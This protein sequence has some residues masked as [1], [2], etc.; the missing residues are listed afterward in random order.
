MI[1]YER[2]VFLCFYHQTNLWIVTSSPMLSWRGWGGKHIWRELWGSFWCDR[3]VVAW[4]WNTCSMVRWFLCIGRSPG[5]FSYN[6]PI[7]SGGG[8]WGGLGW[9]ER[10]KW[11]RGQPLWDGMAAVI[12]S[13]GTDVQLHLLPLPEQVHQAG[14]DGD[15]D[16]DD[17]DDEQEGDHAGDHQVEHLPRVSQSVRHVR[18][19][20]YSCQSGTICSEFWICLLI[21]LRHV[22]LLKGVP[23]LPH[24]HIHSIE[25][26]PVLLL[27]WLL[28]LLGKGTISIAG[29]RLPA[30]DN[31]PQL[32]RSNLKRTFWESLQIFATTVP[33]QYESSWK[34]WEIGAAIYIPDCRWI[35][36]EILE[37][38]LRMKWKVGPTCIPPSVSTKL[39]P[40]S[41]GRPLK[42]FCKSLQVI[43]WS[44]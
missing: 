15:D 4:L 18:G 19:V 1:S 34:D 27:G 6:C 24:A 10:Q 32:Y 26:V 12:A 31:K 11:R 39:P 9:C 14:D 20:R 38:C 30:W 21:V 7:W 3:L 35:S 41:R 17:E 16:G 13:P 43:F 5:W 36:S 42:V 8:Q 33:G 22:A 40:I 44:W 25:I 2:M 23:K 37:I 28:T 29:R